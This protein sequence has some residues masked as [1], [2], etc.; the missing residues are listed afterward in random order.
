MPSGSCAIDFSKPTART[1]EYYEET[2]EIH[3]LGDEM[4]REDSNVLFLA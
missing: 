1:D 4:R 2:Y 3:A